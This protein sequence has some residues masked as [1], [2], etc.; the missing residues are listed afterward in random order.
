M[1]RRSD[2]SDGPHLRISAVAER[3]GISRQ[4]IKNYE[5]AGRFPSPKRDG[6]GWRYYTEED[7]LKL[8]AFFLE[9]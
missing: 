4:T 2:N 5:D 9:D 6:R 3:L 7:V 8:R 1:A